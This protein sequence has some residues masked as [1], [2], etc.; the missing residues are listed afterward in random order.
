MT[1]SPATPTAERPGTWEPL[2]LAELL[3]TRLCHDLSGAVG[4]AA[5]AL[6]LAAEDA[7]AAAEATML[8]RG[9]THALAARL[10]LLRAA[11]GGGD[12]ALSVADLRSL[13]RGL[14]G[15]TV[16]AVFDELSGS[17]PS[18]PQ[19]GRL[20]LN[21]LLLAAESLPGGGTIALCGDIRREV[22]VLLDGPR[23]G[24]PSGLALW[25]VDPHAA[26]EALGRDVSLA[27]ATR[28]VQGPLTALIAHETGLRIAM[29]IAAGRAGAAPPLIVSMTRES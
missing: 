6:D 20:M 23:A 13:A 15:E 14:P 25:L 8:A 2:R 3:A 7:D 28:R 27:V 16:E 24:W 4:A 11:W 5:G 21:V 18:L 9:A 19:A 1:A 29:P 17:R 10:R 12:A 26:W 22:M